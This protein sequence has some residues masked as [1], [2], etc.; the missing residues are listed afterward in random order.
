[1]KKLAITKIL[2]TSEV[3][4]AEFESDVLDDRYEALREDLVALLDKHG[5]EYQSA[6]TSFL[7]FSKYSL[8]RCQ[9][10]GNYMTDRHENPAGLEGVSEHEELVYQGATHEGNQLCEMCLPEGHRWALA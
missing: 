5:F 1:M 7:G 2:C 6:E 9:Q 8:V 3:S 4:Q 10:C